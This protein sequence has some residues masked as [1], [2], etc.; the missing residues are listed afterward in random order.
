[1]Q[2]A[3]RDVRIP[4][5]WNVGMPAGIMA[6][7]SAPSGPIARAITGGARRAIYTRKRRELTLIEIDAHDMLDLSP[8]LG[9]V[10][11][12]L[13]VG[14]VVNIEAAPPVVRDQHSECGTGLKVVGH[15]HVTAPAPGASS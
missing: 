12:C 1:M 13:G 2:E 7:A 8:D 3:V 9:Q 4:D 11:E 10:G 14:E 5:R 15:I 6:S